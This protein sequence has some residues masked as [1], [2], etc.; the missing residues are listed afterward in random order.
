MNGRSQCKLQLAV[1]DRIYAHSNMMARDCSDPRKP[2]APF[3]RMSQNDPFETYDPP[4]SR[5]SE[6]PKRTFPP[7]FT[8][9]YW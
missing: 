3:C 1:L 5:R 8:E 4:R 2:P 9:D 7:I 6:L